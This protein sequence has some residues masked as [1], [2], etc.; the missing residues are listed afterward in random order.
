MVVLAAS[1]S[2]NWCARPATERA[3]IPH[4]QEAVIALLGRG[5]VLLSRVVD[6]YGILVLHPHHEVVH[7]AFQDSRAAHNIFRYFR[8][9]RVEKLAF[10]LDHDVV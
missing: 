3:R 10:P 8:C 7:E 1:S 2:T 5:I 9:A 4:L 6:G